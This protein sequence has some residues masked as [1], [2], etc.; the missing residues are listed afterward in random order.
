MI[1]NS[2]Y[3]IEKLNLTK[4][5]EG[6]YFKETYRAAEQIAG[7]HLP[8]RY[9][10]ARPFSTAI[11]FLLESNDI[12]ALH[13]LKSDEIWH[14]YCG[15]S[16]TIY[17]IDYGGKLSQI[18]LGKSFEQG[19]VF[20]AHINA[21]SWIGAKVNKPDSFSLTG[22][23]VAPGFVFDDFELG[24]RTELLTLYPQHKKLIEVLTNE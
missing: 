1:T 21:G 12:S 9:S 7:N 14:F 18:K 11:Y 16:L 13:R 10:S 20:Q 19:E 6:G 4:H 15:S 2:K 8:A 22:C 24:K 3:W 23:T 5:P 17:C